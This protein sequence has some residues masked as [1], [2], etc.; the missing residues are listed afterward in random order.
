[1]APGALP[2][3]W[4]GWSARWREA[5]LPT[6]DPA[7]WHFIYAGPAAGNGL[8]DDT[9][10][11]REAVIAAAFAP[12][13][14][15]DRVRGAGFYDNAGVCL[16]CGR[17]YCREHWNMTASGFGTCPQGHGKSLDEHWSPDDDW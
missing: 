8:G 2:A 11:G 15:A 14:N 17:P 1:M 3:A 7:R 10:E 6:R 5:Y 4:D 12:A 9:S 13:V 16:P